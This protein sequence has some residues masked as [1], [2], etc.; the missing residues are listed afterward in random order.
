MFAV[1]YTFLDLFASIWTDYDDL[2]GNENIKEIRD[3]PPLRPRSETICVAL[4]TVLAMSTI[5]LSLVTV[6][7]QLA[8]SLE[9]FFY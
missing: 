2:H 9:N 5:C 3:P 1:L 4:S 7:L 8:F 6:Q